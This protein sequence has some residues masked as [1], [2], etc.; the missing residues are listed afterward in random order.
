MV[1]WTDRRDASGDAMIPQHFDEETDACQM[2]IKWGISLDLAV[3]L[4]EMASNIP[5]GLTI[6]SGARTPEHQDRLREEGKRTA[7]NDKS[8]HLSCPATGADVRMTLGA[9]NL[10]NRSQILFGQAANIVGLRWGGGSAQDPAKKGII[11]LDW[12]HLDLGPR[13]PGS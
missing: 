5:F 12:N 11:P 9:A 6:F 1:G 7:D 3:R 4:V 8:T 13:I 10:E 2:A